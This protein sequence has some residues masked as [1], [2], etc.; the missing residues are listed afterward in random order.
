MQTSKD[1]L[2]RKETAE[3]IGQ[4]VRPT[5]HSIFG[6]KISNNFGNAEILSLE[7]R[8]RLASNKAAYITQFPRK[9]SSLIELL[10]GFGMPI[11][12][13]QS[14]IGTKTSNCDPHINYVRV[15]STA[16]DAFGYEADGALPVH[17]ARSW[18]DPRPSLFAMLMVNSG[19]RLG[20]GKSGESILVKWSDAFRW[21]KLKGGTC[22]DQHFNL[23]KNVR[24][25]FAAK[26]VQ[27]PTSDLP[28]V[29]HLRD[30]SGELDMGLRLRSDILDI[31]D[32][33]RN[34]LSAFEHYRAAV[35][36]LL[37]AVNATESQI[38]YQMDEGDLVIVDNNRFG[39]GRCDVVG[40]R[41]T[42]GI[43]YTNPR[44]LWSVTVDSWN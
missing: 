4:Q 29:Y 15:A 36:E 6:E 3:K 42:D 5:F 21:G 33:K 19:W 44:E 7:I 34:Q 23:L 32:E 13:Y 41:E 14:T 10:R 37:S 11:E 30:P 40:R 24:L 26:R 12:N 20:A 17:S 8:A 39:H 38:T 22:W 18:R 16:K 31:V 35:V 25:R 9:E 43:L 28:L 2:M 27:E 1:D